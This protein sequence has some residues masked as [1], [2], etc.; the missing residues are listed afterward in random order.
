MLGKLQPRYVGPYKVTGRTKLGNYV[1][2]SQK[3][4]Q[5]KE[6]TPISKLK[7]CSISS[8]ESYEVEKILQHRKIGGKFQYLV[9]WAGYSDAECSWTNE[10]DFVS[11]DFIRDYWRQQLHDVDVEAVEAGGPVNY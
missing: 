9:K 7:K 1:L 4:V 10:E 3:G 2:V 6:A 8:E 5:L 11:S